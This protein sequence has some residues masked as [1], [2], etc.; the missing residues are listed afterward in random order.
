MVIMSSDCTLI[1]ISDTLWSL[2]RLVICTSE[3]VST[4]C[5]NLTFNVCDFLLR[6]RLFS[7]C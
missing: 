5:C 6:T 4:S 3:R 2:F 1:A 7:I